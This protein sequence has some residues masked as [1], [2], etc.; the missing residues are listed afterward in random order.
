[1]GWTIKQSPDDTLRIYDESGTIRFIGTLPT[2][3]ASL[4][5]SL[6][7]IERLRAE[8][9]LRYPTAVELVAISENK[10]REGPGVKLYCWGCRFFHHRNPGNVF[11]GRTY[12]DVGGKGRTMQDASTP[13]FC[14]YIGK[15]IAMEAEA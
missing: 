11:G 2:A 14:P 15:P 10:D 12:C 5:F 9:K 8:M 1:M 4:A 13:G 6:Q 3:L 7:E